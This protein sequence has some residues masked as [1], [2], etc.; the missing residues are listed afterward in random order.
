[1][2]TF[3][4]WYENYDETYHNQVLGEITSQIDYMKQKVALGQDATILLDK[5]KQFV[6]SRMSELDW[7]N[8]NTIR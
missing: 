8:K 4:K 5:L 6:I 1:M 2:G 7:H 3:S